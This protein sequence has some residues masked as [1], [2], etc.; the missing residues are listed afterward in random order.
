MTT[1]NIISLSNL[2]VSIYLYVITTTLFFNF[3]IF[4]LFS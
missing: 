2:P 3:D 1:K 4:L